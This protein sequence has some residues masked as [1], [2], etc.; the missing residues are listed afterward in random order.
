MKECLEKKIPWILDATNSN[1]DLVVEI[2]SKQSPE[3]ILRLREATADALIGVL[4]PRFRAGNVKFGGSK[5]RPTTPKPNITPISQR[6]GR[7]GY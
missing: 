1:K 4:P 3:A 5:P 7:S 6:K 2:L